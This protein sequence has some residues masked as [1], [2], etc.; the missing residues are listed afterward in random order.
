[1]G[2][3]LK[4]L[5]NVKFRFLQNCPILNSKSIWFHCLWVLNFLE[6]QRCPWDLSQIWRFWNFNGSIYIW[7]LR[8]QFI[9]LFQLFLQGISQNHQSSKLH[10]HTESY[11]SW[12][13]G[14]WTRLF[15]DPELKNCLKLSNQTQDSHCVW[16]GGDPR[17]KVP[18]RGC[19]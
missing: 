14:R 17:V 4:F 16:K 13:S 15:P 3:I 7:A 19:P 9:Y 6:L 2:Q 1:V 8:I 11:A 10:N 18:S 5:E 12:K